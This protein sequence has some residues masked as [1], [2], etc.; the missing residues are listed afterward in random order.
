MNEYQFLFSRFNS[1]YPEPVLTDELR[2][3]LIQNGHT[4]DSADLWIQEHAISGYGYSVKSLELLG[5]ANIVVT[6]RLEVRDTGGGITCLVLHSGYNWSPDS[7]S[8]AT[9]Y[10]KVLAE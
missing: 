4:N 3:A 2:Y 10:I 5:A 9:R 7:Y 8:Y 6:E 1:G